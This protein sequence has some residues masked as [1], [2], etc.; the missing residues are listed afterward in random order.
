MARGRPGGSPGF[1]ALLHSL[2][3]PAAESAALGDSAAGK[4][5]FLGKGQC[6]SCHMVFGG[7]KPVGPDL[8]DVGSRMTVEEIQIG[9]AHV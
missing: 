4:Q 9:R 7:G 3:A 1:A 6:A 5:F 2:N 8:T